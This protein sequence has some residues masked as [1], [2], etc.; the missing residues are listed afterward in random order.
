MEMF[1][2]QKRKLGQTS[3]DVSPI[4][5]GGN[6]FGWT[7]DEASSFSLLDAMVD[8]GIDFIDTADVYSRWVPGNQ[9]GESETII[10]KWLK[11]SGKR[12]EVV[13]ATKVANLERRPGLSQ[14][15]IL[16]AIDD[17][18]RR[19]QTDYVDVCFSH[20]DDATVPLEETL[21]AYQRL[22]EA[23]KVRVIGASNYTGARLQEA[24]STSARHGLPAYQVVQPEYNLYDRRGY[25]TDIEPVALEHKLAVVTYYALASGF[26]SGKYRSRDDLAKSKRGSGIEKYLDERGTKILAALDRVSKRHGTTPASVAL[27]WQLARPSV[28]API[29]SATSQEQL[30]AL[31][32]A[33]GLRLE[34]DDIDALN[35]A[36]AW[37]A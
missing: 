12:H 6:V 22:I 10:G 31:V 5:F 32:A 14:A 8:T 29:A 16:A 30:K 4:V 11:K 24:L 1:Q 23:G 37:S 3:L 13:I 20:H 21:G 35:R 28:T 18:L 15:N 33:A 19:L 9:G 17:S 2:M 26:L 34:A 36:S 27:A 7:V 25:E